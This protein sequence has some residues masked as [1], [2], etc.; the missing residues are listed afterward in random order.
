MGNAKSSDGPSLADRLQA[1]L[2]AQ[3][4]AGKKD[5]LLPRSAKNADGRYTLLPEFFPMY[6][7]MPTWSDI[8]RWRRTVAKNELPD[9]ETLERELPVTTPD[10]A[11]LEKGPQLGHA[12]ATWLGH[13]SVLV[14]WEGWNVLADPIFS[15]RCSFSQSIGPRRCRPSPLQ[16]DGLPRIDAVV[17]SHNHYDHLDLETVKSL[18]KMRPPPIWFVPL[19]T[20]SWMAEAAGVHNVVEMDWSESVT[21]TADD[22]GQARPPLTISCVPCQHWCARG[23]FDKNEMLWS[24]WVVRTPSF[25][26]FFGGDSGYCSKIFKLTSQR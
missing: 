17:I 25:S 26:Y 21:L 8:N 6:P 7:G 14:Q 23:L 13:A 10:K 2:E 12:M 18:A 19:G 16:V 5:S 1:E 11:M 20:K 22:G 3:R 9:K 15:E 4:L 24:A